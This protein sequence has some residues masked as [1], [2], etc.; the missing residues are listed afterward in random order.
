[1][2]QQGKGRGRTRNT[3]THT[4]TQRERERGREREREEYYSV[5]KKKELLP[6]LLFAATWMNWAGSGGAL[7]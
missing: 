6:F 3:H 2:R 4:H 5:I 1:M 7:F